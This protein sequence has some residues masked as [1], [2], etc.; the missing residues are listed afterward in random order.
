M[1]SYPPPHQNLAA[2]VPDVAVG[3]ALPYESYCCN[4]TKLAEVTNAH[5]LVRKLHPFLLNPPEELREAAGLE[6]SE[7]PFAADSGLAIIKAAI[8]P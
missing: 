5:S 2:A 8:I 4:R 3:F 1:G 6:F 7:I